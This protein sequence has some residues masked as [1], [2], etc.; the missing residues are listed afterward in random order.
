[1]IR[2]QS[3]NGCFVHPRTN[4]L[5]DSV[6]VVIVARGTL[7]RNYYQGSQLV[8]WSTDGTAPDAQVATSN[9]QANRCMDCTQSIKRGGYNRGAACKFYTVLTVAFPEDNIVCDLRIS[10]LSLFST[11]V[12]RLSWYKYI[13]YL[14]RNEEEV[15]NILTELYFVESY[16]SHQVY[17]KPVRPLAEEELATVKQLIK[18][19]SQ[20]TNP[21]IGNTEELFMANQSHIIKGVEA[22]YPR[23][24]KPYRFDNK[25]GKN[26]KSVP[27]DPTEDGARY[28]LDFTLSSQQAKTLYKL[29]QGAYTNAKSR[30]DSWPE[31]LEMPFKKQEDGTFL[32]KSSL[33][34]AYSGSVTE[35]PAQFDAKNARLGNDFMLTTGSTVNIAVE[36]I[37]YKMATTG[38][39]LRVR[40]VQVLKYLP[41]KPPSPFG[42]EDGFT[43]GDATDMFAEEAGEDMFATE[44]TPKK[45][46][47]AGQLD[48]FDEPEEV[49]AP[50]KRKSKKAA[51]PVKDEDIADIVGLWGDED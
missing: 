20:P 18:T 17:F 22:R 37:P 15:E 5:S 4:S 3:N 38:V 8:C 24:D 31:K 10:A 33:K 34:A 26:G 47:P 16:N 41:Y 23:L 30:D 40:G 35:P 7:S 39:S 1:M 12:N 51:A 27:C 9:K 6:E 43:A 42:E 48:L 25:A 44:E 32:G 21:F 36:L 14:E 45:A 29:M 50:V 11:T 49:A 13:E 46:E 2:L 28:E 19:V